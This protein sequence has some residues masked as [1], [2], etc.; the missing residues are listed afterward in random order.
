MKRP[1]FSRR[2]G[3]ALALLA[4]SVC[5]VVSAQT[6]SAPGIDV[7][8]YNPVDGSNSF[9]VVPFEIFRAHVFV[10]PGDVS[11]TCDLTCGN[12]VSGG[13]ASLAAGVIDV[14]F[15]PAR[16]SI[17]NAESNSDPGYAA[18]DGLVQLQNV[19][20]GR[21][22]W[23]LAGDWINDGDPGSGL[24]NPCVMQKLDSAGWVFR[25]LLE[26]GT[27]GSTTLH[28]RRQTDPSSFALS[29]AD[30]CGSEAYTIANGGVNEV[31]DATVIIDAA[32]SPLIFE[33]GFEFGDTSRWSATVP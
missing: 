11:L 15:N 2:I 28:L 18:V 7:E 24:N 32:C 20:E 22:G 8:I 26:A 6:T 30:I 14:G 19:G 1:R 10:R 3:P 33:D 17:A 4:V 31:V 21:V 13:S 16:L 23:A 29:F 5:S 25:L 9:C 27:E 12:D